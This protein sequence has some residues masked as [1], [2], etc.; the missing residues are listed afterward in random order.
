MSEVWFFW[1]ERQGFVG[2][3]PSQAISMSSSCRERD[4]VLKNKWRIVIK[5]D[6][7]INLWPPQ[8]YKQYTHTQVGGGGVQIFLFL[9]FTSIRLLSFPL[10]PISPGSSMNSALPNS[11]ETVAL[12]P[13]QWLQLDL[14]LFQPAAVTPQLQACFSG[15]GPGRNS[16]PTGTDSASAA[17][18]S[19]N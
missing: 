19:F 16:A 9:E 5:E 17:E 6:T 15:S 13:A 3:Q 2:Q 1:E 14:L 11:M 7:N 10:K 12:S 8:V 4:P 18:G